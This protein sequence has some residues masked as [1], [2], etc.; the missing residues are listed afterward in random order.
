MRIS[1]PFSLRSFRISVG[2]RLVEYLE[3]YS[4]TIPGQTLRH[5]F[6]LEQQPLV[7]QGLGYP[8]NVC[9]LSGQP[10]EMSQSHSENVLRLRRKDVPMCSLHHLFSL[11]LHSPRRTGASVLLRSDPETSPPQETTTHAEFDTL[12]QDA[13]S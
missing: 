13:K 8:R 11:Q 12:P 4:A 9:G 10:T 5:Q 7:P 2:S 1:S 6:L 3:L